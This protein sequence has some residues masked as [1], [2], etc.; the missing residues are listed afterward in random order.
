MEKRGLSYN[1]D[2]YFPCLQIFSHIQ[3][4][5]NFPLLH[6]ETFLVSLMD[7]NLSWIHLAWFQNLYLGNNSPNLIY[8]PHLIHWMHY[9]PRHHSIHPQNTRCT[10]SR[11]ACFLLRL[12]TPPS[13]VPEWGSAL[14]RLLRSPLVQ[15][16][17]LPHSS[18]Q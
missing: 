14:Q 12:L 17:A 10:L 7:L 18:G 6:F 3:G 5:G 9:N 2:S 15:G 8:L 13:H 1:A 16:V 11:C 4:K